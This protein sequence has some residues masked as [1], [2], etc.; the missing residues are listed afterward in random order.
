[1]KTQKENIFI[2]PILS[3]YDSLNELISDKTYDGNFSLLD[4]RYR[5]N[6]NDFFTQNSYFILGEPGSGKSTLLNE[7]YKNAA[8][9]HFNAHFLSLPEYSNEKLETF[10]LEKYQEGLREK[11]DMLPQD[12]LFCFDSLDEV[13]SDRFSEIL[14]EIVSLSKTYS[15][16][17]I[18]SCRTHYLSK[19]FSNIEGL[20]SFSYIKIQPLNNT[21]IKKYIEQFAGAE[22]IDVLEKPSYYSNYIQSVLRIPRYLKIQIEIA[23]ES[24]S[25]ENFGRLKRSDLFEK[26]IY[27]KLEREKGEFNKNVLTK[28]VLE[29]LALIME[30]YQ[31]NTITKDELITFL[32]E[33]DSNINL[34]FLNS[35]NIED[36]IKRV[37]KHSEFD[38]IEFDN[39]EFQEY[40]AAKELLRLGEKS[41]ILFDLILEP[42]FKQIYPNWFD[43]L[44]YVVEIDHNQLLNMIDFLRNSTDKLISE[45]FFT[46]LRS[47]DLKLFTEQQKSKVFAVAF[48]Y[49]QTNQV[50]IRSSTSILHVFYTDKNENVFDSIDFSTN[51]VVTSNQLSTL[52]HLVRNKRYKKTQNLISKIKIEIFNISDENTIAQCIQILESNNKIDDLIGIG[53]IRKRNSKIF[54]RICRASTKIDPNHRYTVL[55]IIQAITNGNQE[56]AKNGVSELNDIVCIKNFLS[57]L[58]AHASVLDKFTLFDGYFYPS[59]YYKL[60]DI[61]SEKWDTEMHSILFN[62]HDY[63]IFKHD[64]YHLHGSGFYMALINCLSKNDDQF[65]GKFICRSDFFFYLPF[66]EFLSENIKL[67]NISQIVFLNDS[68]NGKNIFESIL[69]NIKLRKKDIFE[70]LTPYLSSNFADL[71]E[72]LNN[73]KEPID[74]RNDLILKNFSNQLQGNSPYIYDTFLK[75]KDLILENSTQ[76][77]IE[78]L[79][80]RTITVLNSV[81]PSGFEI[82]MN[83]TEAAGRRLH[84]LNFA[85]SQSGRIPRHISFV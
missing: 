52:K 17:F 71:F 72:R 41:Q 78:A 66:I 67:S 28:R 68:N 22:F 50:Y 24:G 79:K 57:F 61:I 81:D 18:I 34:I 64:S 27:Q 36:F 76:E 56:E 62:I 12:Y 60:F 75:N 54:G 8:S 19:N 53:K 15:F 59:E 35:E 14:R 85:S 5:F 2:Q 10:I 45:D 21:Q 13:A 46:L 29:K 74:N 33:T 77:E 84:I 37:L 48:N 11:L 31:V 32:D 83:H 38:K 49:F 7:I 47:V 51:S 25:A 30:I 26:F 65:I 23:V 70:E 42:N 69:A 9:H 58:Y 3:K 20:K 40:L 73:Y 80:S 55:L 6:Y 63:L 39:T 4:K 82:R 1:M 44:K 16:K 43:V